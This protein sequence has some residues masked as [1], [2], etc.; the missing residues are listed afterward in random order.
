VQKQREVAQ[1]RILME[2]LGVD[3]SRAAQAA[4]TSE[5][6]RLIERA[7]LSQSESTRGREQF[8]ERQRSAQSA[9]RRQGMGFW[10]TA[11]DMWGEHGTDVR[12]NLGSWGA[13]EKS[14][15]GT[16]GDPGNL[17]DPFGEAEA[18]TRTHKSGAMPVKVEVM[19][20]SAP[21]AP[22]TA[23]QTRL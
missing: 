4:G 1:E 3:A 17:F 6:P 9:L 2:G 10:G 23:G 5:A 22:T 13:G 7:L 11:M 18:Y 14:L 16:P 19:R 15:R 8:R 12:A 20:H 21:A